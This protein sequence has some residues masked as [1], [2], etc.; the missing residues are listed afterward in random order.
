MFNGLMQRPV[1]RVQCATWRTAAALGLCQPGFRA[2][3]QFRDRQVRLARN[4]VAN[5]IRE[6]RR[7][8]QGMYRRRRFFD[9][10][11]HNM[12]VPAT[13]R[14]FCEWFCWVADI[15]GSADPGYVSNVVA[16][17][18]GMGNGYS[19]FYGYAAPA[20]EMDARIAKCVQRLMWAYSVCVAHAGVTNDAIE[21]RLRKMVAP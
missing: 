12:G 16:L 15:N 2:L 6:E 7:A 18:L 13:I 14:A 1:Y 20:E 10:N 4:T 21:A 9:T 11:L 17:E 19:I 8:G 5:T 3:P